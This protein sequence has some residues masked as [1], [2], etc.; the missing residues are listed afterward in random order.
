MHIKKAGIV[1]LT[2]DKMK[3]VEGKVLNETKEGHFYNTEG[4]TSQQR[5]KWYP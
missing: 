4:H 1:T 3:F 5:Y 2:Y